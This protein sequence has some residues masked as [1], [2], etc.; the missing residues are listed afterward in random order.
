MKGYKNLVITFIVLFVLFVFTKLTAPKP[1]EWVETLRD[2]EKKPYD[3]YIL[4]K[5]LPSLFKEVKIQN[6]TVPFY[7]F[8]DENLDKNDS[9]QVYMAIAPSLPFT[10]IE[11]KKLLTFVKNGNYAFL[12]AESFGN[13]LP[14]SLRASVHMYF[15]DVL[16]SSRVNFADSTIR[17]PKG[18]DFF[19]GTIDKY[20]D[21]LPKKYIT[22]KLGVI[23][24]NQRT[25]FI[26][27]NIG[28]GSMYLHAAPICFSNA[29]Q[30]YK[31]NYHYTEQVLSFLPKKIHTLYWDQYYSQGRDREAQTPFRYFLS[32]FWLRIGFYMAWILLILYVLFSGKR[33]Q[34]LIPI[35]NPPR[36]T[37]EDFINTISS[38]Y[39]NQ[40]SGPEIFEKKVY[41]WL[42]YIRD[43]LQLNTEDVTT[44][45][46]WKKLSEKSNV[47]MPSLQIIREQ[48]IALQTQYNDEIFKSLYKN[49]ESFYQKAKK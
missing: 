11:V 4:H 46:F 41:R 3:T 6:T 2:D 14:D 19:A 20:F 32:H 31:N 17:T 25:N 44:D 30:L 16:D 7:N 49:I 18:Y 37:T 43:H 9:N 23:E 13:F 34:R 24:Q 36:N 12:S 15:F 26:K 48:I 40:K 21:S 42:A 29:F 5:S 39:Y 38:L 28:K 22:E 1:T 33:R 35:I 27:I 45:D 8:M 10:E 47:D